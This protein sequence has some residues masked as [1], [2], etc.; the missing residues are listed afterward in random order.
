MND[1]KKDVYGWLETRVPDS[2]GVTIG[3]SV[4]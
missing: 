1:M 4:L 3:D 2:Y